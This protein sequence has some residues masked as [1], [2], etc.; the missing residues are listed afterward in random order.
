FRG[1]VVDA[2]YQ[3][4]L[5]RAADP[6]GHDYFVWLMGLGVTVEQ[7]E[8]VLI[9]SPEFY[10][11]VGGDGPTYLFAVYRH[12]LGRAIDSA[13]LTAWSGLGS[14]NNIMLRTLAAGLI[15]SSAEA[16][17][18]LVQSQYQKLLH[19]PVDVPGLTFFAGAM[20]HGLTDQGLALLLASSD[21]YFAQF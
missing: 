21:E 15:V 8:T 16:N 18:S 20:T 2:L 6:G 9:S 13:G 5:G 7:V 4:L 17:Q 11:R 19:R 1:R 10:Q 12:L 14:Y 3:R